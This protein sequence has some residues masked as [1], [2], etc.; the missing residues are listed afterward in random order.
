MVFDCRRCGVCCRI[1]NYGYPYVG[2]LWF[3]DIVGV[4]T[5]DPGALVVFQTQVFMTLR[6]VGAHGKWACRW[7]R[8][9]EPHCSRY[10]ARPSSC[11]EFVPGGERCLEWLQLQADRSGSDVVVPLVEGGTRVFRP[12]V[13]LSGPGESVSVD[14]G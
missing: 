3:R 6:A 12:R 2:P 13:D 5:E 9:R 14:G 4:T 8:E 7:W 1:E 10:W 11:R